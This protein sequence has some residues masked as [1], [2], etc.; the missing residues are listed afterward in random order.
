MRHL[1]APG[2]SRLR[3]LLRRLERLRYSV[4]LLGFGS[5]SATEGAYMQGLAEVGSALSALHD[6]QLAAILPRRLHTLDDGDKAVLD[7]IAS[8]HADQLALTGA[9]ALTACQALPA[10]PPS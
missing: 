5:P 3:K 1:P 2:I 8:A 9:S 10:L 6:A 7:G 4:A